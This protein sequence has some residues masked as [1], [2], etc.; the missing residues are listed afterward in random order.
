MCSV[1]VFNIL[2]A[3]RCDGAAVTL[4]VPIHGWILDSAHISGTVLTATHGS[5]DG[6]ING[7][8]ALAD[9]G[10]ALSFDGVD[11]YIT[12]QSQHLPYPPLLA[13]SHCSPLP[14]VEDCR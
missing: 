13:N 9:D 2:L 3:L 6:V 1:L 10:T 11:D 12:V 14:V 5:Y 7:D 8:P 4:P